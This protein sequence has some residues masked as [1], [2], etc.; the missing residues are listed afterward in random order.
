MASTTSV[1]ALTRFTALAAGDVLPVCDISDTSQSAHGSLD[2]I[3]V[4][5]F[6]ASVPSP[7]TVTCGTITASAPIFTGTQTWNNAGVTFT[8]L[9][10]TVTD[11]ASAA[12]SLLVSITGPVSVFQ[13]RK[14][15][16][17]GIGGVADST[18]ALNINTA[19]ALTSTNQ[20]G[21][22]C[23]PFFNSTCTVQGVAINAAVFTQAAAFT[24]ANA[25][26]VLINNATIGAGSAITNQYGL[27]VD[28]IS[29]AATLNY[30]IY[31]NAGKVRFGDYTTVAATGGFTIGDLTSTNRLE[32]G[33]TV[34]STFSFI[35]S[36]NGFTSI[37]ALNATFTG[38]TTV[39]GAFGCNGATAQTSVASGGALAAYGAGANG[40]DSGAN[41]AAL[42]AL[43]VAMRA[44]LVSN[45]IMS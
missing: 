9:S 25:Y 10:L 33:N 40:L 27:Y 16:S 28:A 20:R 17:V 6:F 4:A 15:G 11:T 31:T 30:A 24:L 43:V 35:N 19:N 13:I 2:A 41:M 36:G 34:A 12:A 21:I 8:G 38:T 32:Y 45:G 18:V 22:N 23:Q 3:T 39:T 44:A 29:G 14:N 7:I 42:H 37:K 26:G 1:F 5:N